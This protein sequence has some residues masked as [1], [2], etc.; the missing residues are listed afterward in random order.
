MSA[1]AD[2][3][4]DAS[5]DGHDGSWAESPQDAALSA[6][7]ATIVD[8]RSVIEQVKGML[9]FIYGVDADAA[10]EIL[11]TR[12]QRHNVKLRSVAEQLS[13]ELVELT[14][15]NTSLERLKSDGVLM[16]AHRRIANS[17]PHRLDGTPTS[18]D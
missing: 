18:V 2:G 11:R 4:T 16:A 12:S 1:G 6:R 14:K 5:V 15:S 13:R 17:A 3:R 7:L 9:M 8:S 10:F